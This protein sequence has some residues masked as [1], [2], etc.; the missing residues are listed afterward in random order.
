[1][2]KLPVACSAEPRDRVGTNGALST[3]VEGVGAVNA[4]CKS[5]L[6][7]YFGNTDYGMYGPA[8]VGCRI[9]EGGLKA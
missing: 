6:T 1:M 2:G 5:Q 9:R 7:N 4:F 3:P 8:N